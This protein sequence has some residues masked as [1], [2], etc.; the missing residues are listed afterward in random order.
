VRALGAFDDERR[1]SDG[2]KGPYGTIDAPD[3]NFLGA[4]EE[5]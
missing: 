3:K 2:A 5:F 4:I 1:A